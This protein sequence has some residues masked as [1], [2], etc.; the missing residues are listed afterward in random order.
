[1]GF[2]DEL[3]ASKERVRQLE[4]ENTAL[5]EAL[6]RNPEQTPPPAA[7]P[8]T[9]PSAAEYV[10]AAFIVLTTGASFYAAMVWLMP[11]TMPA[12]ARESQIAGLVG[13]AASAGTAVLFLC[14]AI[15]GWTREDGAWARPSDRDRLAAA[16]K[17]IGLI[18]LWMLAFLFTDGDV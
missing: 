13:A 18:V 15:L 2:R 8:P 3:A 4:A 14:P 6:E 5:R 1:M 9:R 7:R 16:A 10:A 11:L 17:G 12:L